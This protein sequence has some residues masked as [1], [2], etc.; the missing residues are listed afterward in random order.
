MRR[1][2][3]HTDL[4]LAPVWRDLELPTGF[5]PEVEAAAARAADTLGSERRDA[6]DIPF[7]T[8]DPPG[9]MDLDQAL[10]LAPRPGGDA[11]ERAGGW[12]V[13]Y[14]IADLAAFVAAGDPVDVEARRRGETLYLP[15]G[16]VPL[17]PPVLSEGTASLLPGVDRPAVLWRIEVDGD[18]EQVDVSVE[19]ATVR[20]RSRHAYVDL[21]AALD[22]GDAPE[23]ARALPD[24]GAARVARARRE[25]AIELGLPSQEVVQRE[26]GSWTIELRAPL[27]VETWNAQVSLLTGMAAAGLMLDAGVGLLRTLPEPDERTVRRLRAGAPA[28]GVDWPGGARPGEVLAAL[29]ARQ[30]R[31]AAFLDLAAELLRG[32]GYKPFD[33]AVPAAPGHAGV[34]APYAHVTAPI[35]RLGD[36]F[37]TEVCLAVSAGREVP[38]WVRDALPLLPDLLADSGRRSRSVERA[39]VDHVEAWLLADRVGETFDAAV[40]EHDGERD[41]CTVV[42]DDPAVRARCD[43]RPPLGER[44]TVRL[45]EAD[46]ATRTVR[47][48]P[49]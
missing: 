41:R 11:G 32:A 49:A 16:R 25:G 36:R 8:V 44:T 39:A 3:L 9:A 34:G 33:G 18:G 6:T 40:V 38:G 21:Q 13:H 45:V 30:P 19:R 1:R 43:G 20:T 15:D 7:V 37:A 5:P 27:P 4:D 24:L 48:A 42:L 35:R 26:D 23:A 14:A 46:L 28:L 17:H 47:F 12:I 22:A 2:P 29:D 31:A 10:H